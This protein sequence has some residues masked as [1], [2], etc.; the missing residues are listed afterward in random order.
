[1]LRPRPALGGLLILAAACDCGGGGGV[2]TDPVSFD[3][4]PDIVDFGRVTLGRSARRALRISNLG[5]GS[6]AI[7]GVEVSEGIRAEIEVQGTPAGLG[8]RGDADLEIV[9]TPTQVG[10]RRDALTFLVDGERF[11]VLVLAT[12]VDPAL[13]AIPDR[14]DFGRVVVG[15][16]AT[17]TVT[18]EN[19]GEGRVKISALAL[20]MGTSSEFVATLDNVTSLDGGE[21]LQFVVRYAPN[22]SGSDSGRVVVADD[23]DDVEPVG[24]ELFGEAITDELEVL[25][26]S[27]LAFEGVFVGEARTMEVELRNVGPNA[28]E[29][30]RLGIEAFSDR[31]FVALDASAVPFTLE[32]GAI[33]RVPVVF[34]PVVSGAFASQLTVESTGLLE[35]AAVT[36]IGLAVEVAAPVAQ[37]EPRLDFGTIAVQHATPR[38][39]RIAN[40]GDA[41]IDVHSLRI[42]PPGA[43]F[44][45]E[46]GSAEWT[47]IGRD[48]RI[49]TVV[50]TP[51]V[52]GALAAELVF[53]TSEVHRVA[54]TATVTAAA[55]D[56]LVET[57]SLDF[58]WVPRGDF[59]QG[60]ID[61]RSVGSEPV[62]LDSVVVDD[63]AFSVRAGALPRTLAPGAVFSIR[64]GFVD[65]SRPTGASTATVTIASSD[66]DPTPRVPVSVTTLPPTSEPAA[67]EFELIWEP[68]DADLDLHVVRRAGAPFDRPGDCC[69]CN[70]APVWTLGGR[71]TS[72]PRLVRE[73]AH[74]LV[75]EEVE[76]ATTPDTRYVVYVHAAA[77][78]GPVQ[79]LVE[80]RGDGVRIDRQERQ[81]GASDY[82]TVGELRVTSGRFYDFEPSKLPLSTENRDRCF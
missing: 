6:L 15:T 23:G 74:G 14:V 80:V 73:S 81:L 76:I 43:P 8:R 9:F 1:M 77:T 36:L 20:E 53:E 54:L 34:A 68:F 5:L 10:T 31:F 39:F 22:G 75:G 33:A 66:P 67:I 46:E 24:V 41:S 28:H 13:V 35:P 70:P 7:D 16:I 72:D 27:G 82:W 63:P 49:I 52:T 37:F 30:T 56:L 65:M 29:V 11:D 78:M 61:V 64:L 19:R 12:V 40:G 51:R 3:V 48:E 44:A 60:R 4:S 55:P 26:A 79:A 21:S 69:F 47:L 57:S 42:E 38:R 2:P 62:R 25:P 17:A 58:G 18:L 71:S 50:A 45:V 32:A 59:A